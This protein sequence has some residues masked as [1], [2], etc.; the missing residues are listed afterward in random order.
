MPVIVGTSYLNMSRTKNNL[1]LVVLHVRQTASGW[2]LPNESYHQ[3][4]CHQSG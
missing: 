4:F 3:T 2:S 1:W